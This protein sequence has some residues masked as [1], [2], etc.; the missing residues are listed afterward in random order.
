MKLFISFAFNE[1][2]IV[3]NNQID[4][5]DFDVNRMSWKSWKFLQWAFSI[6]RRLYRYVLIANIQLF[7][8]LNCDFI[9]DKMQN[10][11]P[12]GVTSSAFSNF[13][14][15]PQNLTRQNQPNL[16][17]SS[18]RSTVICSN[19]LKRTR[20]TGIFL[21][22]IS[23]IILVAD[24]S[25]L[26]MKFYSAPLLVTDKRSFQWKH[27]PNIVYDF[28][29][30]ICVNLTLCDINILLNI[31]ESITIIVLLVLANKQQQ[32]R[33]NGTASSSNIIIIDQCHRETLWSIKDQI[34]L[35]V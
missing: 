16:R 26:P 24:P 21:N 30:H 9:D 8:V 10:T 14:S 31:Y 33:R 29:V 6:T 1:T 32:F 34:I 15:S 17:C 13:H 22:T 28:K 7:A 20:Y 27:L 35:Y 12:F 18:A 11:P 19:L 5:L 23:K 25:Y 3:K 2:F 4:F